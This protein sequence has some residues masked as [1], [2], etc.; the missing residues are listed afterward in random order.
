MA[1]L[2]DVYASAQ[3][4]VVRHV[5]NL[6]DE[7]LEARVPATREWT[8]RDVVA[9]LVGDLDCLIRADFPRDFFESFGEAA[10]VA[11]LNE[12]TQGQIEARKGRSLDE[13]V[14]EWNQLTHQ[15][16]PLMRGEQAWPDGT[17]FFVDRVLVTDIGVHQQDIYGAAGVV[18]DRNSAP[19]KIGTS[20]Y[21]ASFDMRLRRDGRMGLVVQAP[22]KRWVIGGDAPS[23]ILTI[24]RFELFRALSGRRSPEQIAAYDWR[25]DP[26]PLIPYFYPYGIRREALLE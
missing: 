18:R 10:A 7:A 19:V 21:L 8:V 24:D 5:M 14:T 9:H 2:A 3:Q 26:E 4:A 25:G 6:S 13:L 12:W 20:S 17:L 22:D 16:L 23:A 11:S 15:I 1:H